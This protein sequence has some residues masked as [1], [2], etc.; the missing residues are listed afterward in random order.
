VRTVGFWTPE[1]GISPALKNAIAAE[2][3]CEEPAA[4]RFLGGAEQGKIPWK[5][6]KERGGS[7]IESKGE[8]WRARTEIHW[9]NAKRSGQASWRKNFVRRRTRH[10]TKRTAQ[11]L[12]ILLIERSNYDDDVASR[13]CMSI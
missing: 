7:L 13:E 1:S 5:R 6:A 2:M 12:L 11:M 8:R 3:N 9:S 4:A 10:E